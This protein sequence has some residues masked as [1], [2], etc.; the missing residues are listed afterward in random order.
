MRRQALRLAQTLGVASQLRR[1]LRDLQQQLRCRAASANA[2]VARL[3]S[4]PCSTPIMTSSPEK[5][6]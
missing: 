1:V 5:N 4:K 2:A 6:T 3:L